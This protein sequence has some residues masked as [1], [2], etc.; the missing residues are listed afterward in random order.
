MSDRKTDIKFFSILQ[1]KK[2]EDYLSWMRSQG[3]K[4]EKISGLCVYHF[5]KCRP[6][7]VVYRLDYNDK[8]LMDKEEYIQMFDDCGWDYI[9]DYMGYSYFCKPVSEMT[10]GDEDIFCDDSSRL[11]ML[12]RVFKGRMIPLLVIFFFTIIPQI[13]I[14]LNSGY[15]QSKFFLALF[16]VLFFIYLYFF[17]N[18]AV[19]YMKITNHKDI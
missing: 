12:K 2:E 6:E 11:D 4:F 17:V 13:F 15:P 19:Q 8:K 10:N 18:F 3:W 1:W 14:Q 9:Q 5:V 16:I 7:R